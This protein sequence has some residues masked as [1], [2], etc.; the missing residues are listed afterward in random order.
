MIKV[1]ISGCD[2]LS[3]AEL[4]RIL[5]NHPDVELLR[6]CD[7]SHA[8]IR[9]DKIVPG[10]IGECDL[11]VCPEGKLDDIDL[12]YL[13]GSR[14]GVRI[15]PDEWR[16]GLKVI[17]LSGS[18]NLEHGDGK[19]W[20]YGMSEMQRR[21]LVHEAQ[22]V[23]VP[24]PAAAASLLALLPMVRNQLLQ[25]PLALHIQ[26]GTAVFPADGKTSDGLTAEAFAHDQQQELCLALRQFQPDFDQPVTLSVSPVGE[27]RTFIVESRFKCNVDLAMMASLY[28]QFYDDHNFVFV[29]DRPLSTADVENTNKF[30]IHLEKDEASGETVV[31]G[32]MDVLLKGAAGNAVHA[33]NLMYG[34]HERVG[35]ALKGSGR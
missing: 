18:H 15:R 9:L 23:T 33:M 20:V 28:E 17:D 31:Q 13:C 34:L 8:G 12:L 6:V 29:V 7:A 4:V 32:M 30:L 10:I 21:V 2:G 1:G 24:G 11:T 26:A 3:V 16:E 35:L 19:P 5:I 14:A 27:R 22:W 25:G